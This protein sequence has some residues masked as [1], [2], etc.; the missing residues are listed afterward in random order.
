MAQFQQKPEEQKAWAGLPAEPFDESERVDVLP[1][2]PFADPL[3][4]PGG[5]VTSVSVPLV[6]ELPS[7]AGVGPL[8]D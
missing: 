7:D 3:G 4:L 1:P 2:A 8:D 5:T 6:F